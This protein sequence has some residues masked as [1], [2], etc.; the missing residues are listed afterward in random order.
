MRKTQT[1]LSNNKMIEFFH[2]HV[3]PIYFNM[4]CGADKRCFIVTSFVM[5]VYDQWFL[6][7]AGH[8]I[9][10]I[11]KLNAAG[12]EIVRCR[13]IDSIGSGASHR[14][15]IPFD[16]AES[17]ATKMC[18]DSNYDYGLIFLEDYYIELLRSNGVIP[19]KEDAWE[20]QPQDP[21]Y[22][23]LIGV[24]DELS[25]TSE[26]V[27]LVTSTFHIVKELAERPPYFKPTDAPT[28]FGKIYLDE[29]MTTIIG[30]SGGPIFSFKTNESGQLKYW[31][32]AVQSRWVK[33][34]KVVAAC[35]MRPLGIFLKEFIEGKHQ[36]KINK[37]T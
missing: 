33:P 21:E 12:Y 25:N 7:T 31:L 34:E 26:D 5:S 18:Y 28:F 1:H 32:H 22:F 13:L 6:V 17:R 8:C 30:M 37:E 15:P 23:A 19:I 16:Y 29:P 11:E 10:D 35:L 4:Q 14:L 27:V 20:K 3:V 2:R 9:E 24:P 36:N